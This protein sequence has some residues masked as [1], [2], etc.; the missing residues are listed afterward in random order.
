MSDL[1]LKQTLNLILYVAANLRTQTC[2]KTPKALSSFVLTA[3]VAV[4][5]A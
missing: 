3:A 5:T 4:E 1:T 2:M